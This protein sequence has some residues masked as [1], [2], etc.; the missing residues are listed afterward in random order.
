MPH[1]AKVNRLLPP[2]GVCLG[3]FPSAGRPKASSTCIEDGFDLCRD[4][5]RLAQ[6][7]VPSRARTGRWVDAWA[8]A[9]AAMDMETYRAVVARAAAFAAGDRA[10][11]LSEVDGQMKHAAAE[12]RFEEAAALKTRLERL[13]SLDGPAYAHVADGQ[14]FQFI[15]VQRGR[16]KGPRSSWP[17]AG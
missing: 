8:S 5:R 6:A 7:P 15:L 13:A 14:A 2:P 3:P 16:R 10:G 9:T 4:S 12:L 1:L 11:L 17:I